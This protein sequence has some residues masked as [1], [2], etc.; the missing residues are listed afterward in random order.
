MNLLQKL[1][2]Q[3]VTIGSSTACEIC[4]P[5]PGVAPIHAEVIHRGGGELTLVPGAGGQ[6]AID[7][8]VLPSGVGVPFDFRRE[9]VVGEVPL[10][11]THPDLCLM[12][13]S[14]GNKPLDPNLIVVGRDPER[15]HLVLASPGVSG[16]H[17]TLHLGKKPTVVDHRSTSGTWFQGKRLTPE[18]HHEIPESAVL[19]I[20]PLPLPIPLARQLLAAF[21]EP[22]T[23]VYA[24]MTQAMPRRTVERPA[25]AS[26]LPSK[27]AARHRTIVGT[28]KMEGTHAYTIGRTADNDI[29]LDY[30][31]LSGHHAKI[32]T[33]GGQVFVEDLKSELGTAVR[34]SRLRHGH[35]AKVTDGERVMFGPLPALV[36][37]DGGAVNIVVEDSEGWAG[38]PL[39]DVSAVGVT[40]QVP[41]RDD[42]KKTKTLLES[43]TF[44]ALPGDL[45]ALMGPSGSGKTTLLHALTGYVRPT[46]GEVRVNDTPLAN[47]FENLRGSIG[48]V[49]QDDII[50]PELTVREAVEYSARFRLPPDYTKAEIENRV[51]KTLTQLGLESVAHL[52]I[53]RPEAKILSGGQRKRVNIA[54]ELV[55]DPVLL[56]LDEPTSGLA[57]DDTTALVDLLARL[58]QDHGKTII[59]TIHQPARDEYEKF[60][61]ALVLGHGGVPL[62]FGPSVEAYSFFEAWRGAGEARGVDT[63][64]DMFA[65]LSERE[66]RLK[67]ELGSRHEARVAVAQAY[68]KEYQASAVRQMMADASRQVKADSV[69]A[70]ELPRRDQP[71]G[72]LALLLS[73]YLKIKARDR[74]GTLILMLQAPLIG[75]LLSLVFSATKPSVPYWC[76]GAL[77]ELS[78]KS[79]SVKEAGSDILNRLSP[80]PDHAGA[81]FFLVVAAVWFGTSNA[82]REIVSER[83]IYR[84]E[85]M[86]NLGVINYTLSKFFILCGLC[87]I[88]CAT[89]LSI[90]FFSLG[91][92]GGTAA[93]VSALGLL[94]LTAFCSVALGLLLS[95]VVASSEA[96]M[97]LTPIALIPQVVLGGLMVPVTTNS[98]LKIPMMFVPSRWGFEGVVAKERMAISADPAWTIALPGVPDSPPDFITGET[99][100]CAMAQMQSS[101]LTGAWGFSF[102]PHL[103]PL[104]LGCMTG[105]LLLSVVV[106]L[107]KRG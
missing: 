11:S 6:T 88:Q 87:V 25:L 46:E 86:V 52:Q 31:Q 15:C 22:V 61:L 28:M 47:I 42:S 79:G 73:R 92:S 57:A 41:D 4:L 105:V 101:Q 58:A 98:M 64:R 53:G 62:Y 63:P 44:K 60:N 16:C 80:A 7:G 18:E 74:V 93:F 49:P 100:Q 59:A 106:L 102:E 94:T 3:T 5:G 56:F 50:H 1:S 54:M 8:R 90:V 24:G 69:R 72:Q 83:A 40:V 23:P 43:V 32:L 67:S 19:A 45:I 2:R 12:V 85:R 97:A 96:A 66:A 21:C 20:G 39:F 84:R 95:T 14:R 9:F 78:N 51:Q 103:P 29:V 36:S 35:R 65:E 77:N 30:P 33:I 27:P 99:F 68:R 10:P 107:A 91:L 13:M 81:L 38:R 55:T 26:R 89:L 82:A 48:Y 70:A 17:A 34:G 75:V 37:I 71:R 104:I 76:L